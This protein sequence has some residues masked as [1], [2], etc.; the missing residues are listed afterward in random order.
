MIEVLIY[1][2]ESGSDSDVA[3]TAHELAGM[4][5]ERSLSVADRDTALSIRSQARAY[6]RTGVMPSRQFLVA[7]FRKVL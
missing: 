3:E 6:C 4:A 1:R 7:F 5:L 2:L